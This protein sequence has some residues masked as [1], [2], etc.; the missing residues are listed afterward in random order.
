M[1][2]NNRLTGAILLS[3]AILTGCRNTEA[4]QEEKAFTLKGDTVYLRDNDALAGK[5]AVAPVG[6]EPYSKE[7]VTAGTVQAIPTQFAYIAPPFSGRITKSYIR[8]GQKVEVDTPLFEI[9]SPEFTEVQK[10]FFQAK[11][12]REL[13]QKDLRRK[14][15]LKRNG[16]A[17]ER[18]YEEALHALHIAEKEYENAYSALQVYQVNPDEMVFGLPLVIR[19]PI[20]GNIISNNVVTGQYLNSDSDPVAVVADLSRVWVVAQVKEKDIRFIHEGDEMVIHVSA[21]P[22]KAINGTVYHVEEAVDEET[23][24]IK[25][26]SIC[27][28]REELLKLG[29]YATVYFLD[30]PADC[31]VI[32]E[33]AILQSEDDS[34]VYV[35]IAPNTFSKRAVGVEITKEGKAIINQGLQPAERIITEGGYYFK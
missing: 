18:E 25:V 14:E 8:I 5:I 13:A 27:D 10:S 17:S 7:V 2:M 21:W 9:N 3:V 24:A 6:I 30:K 31:I 28:N 11:S 26:L 34:Y 15:D 23:R 35:E 16:V 29:M 20:K 12:E 19:S 1:R 32:P 4:V 22:G 33:K